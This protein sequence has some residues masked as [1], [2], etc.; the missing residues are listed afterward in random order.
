VQHTEDQNEM[1]GLQLSDEQTIHRIHL[2]IHYRNTQQTTLTFAYQEQNWSTMSNNNAQPCN[3]FQRAQQNPLKNG[4]AT[5]GHQCN[6]RSL[7]K[8]QQPVSLS[9][10][11][12]HLCNRHEYTIQNYD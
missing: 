11:Y 4:Q 7:A 1:T 12:V 2:H 8:T 6:M 10:R 3:T 5:N 9:S